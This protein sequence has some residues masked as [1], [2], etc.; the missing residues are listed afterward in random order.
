MND[1]ILVIL[2]IEH[3]DAVRSIDAILA[4][5]GVTSLVIGSNDLSGSMG[6]TGQP[7]HP[8][9]LAAIEM[10]IAVAR[11]AEIFIGIAIGNDPTTITEW[12]GK[13]I[14]WVAMGSDFGLML[15]ALDDVSNQVREY[16]ANAANA[17]ATATA[18]AVPKRG[19]DCGHSK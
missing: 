5:P 8:D 14:Q 16:L 6:L 19:P 4:V 7:R 12:I 1:S 17:T 18:T 10:V 9:V 13:G 11:R 15:R 3:I 2:Q